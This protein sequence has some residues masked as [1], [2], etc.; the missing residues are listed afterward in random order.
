MRTLEIKQMEKLKGGQ[1]ES[2]M[3]S[4]A[5]MVAFGVA[6]V[7]TAV[8]AGPSLIGMAAAVALGGEMLSAAGGCV[9]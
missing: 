5:A 8:F 4:C 6:G 3:Y 1:N 9:G 7:A 2:Q